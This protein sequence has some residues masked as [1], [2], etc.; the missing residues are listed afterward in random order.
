MDFINYQS[1]EKDSNNIHPLRILVDNVNQQQ[2][3]DLQ[4][5]SASYKKKL[6]KFV[7]TMA[8]K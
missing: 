2:T 1:A 4:N 6:K 7:I 5:I 3:I 8:I